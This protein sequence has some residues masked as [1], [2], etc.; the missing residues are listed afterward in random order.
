MDLLTAQI[1]LA[2]VDIPAF[3][4]EGSRKEELQWSLKQLDG[5][6]DTVWPILY[7]QYLRRRKRCKVHNAGPAN[8]WLRE[9]VGW[10]QKILAKLPVSLSALRNE[11][12]RAEVAAD[13]ANQ[14]AQL[15]HHATD[16]H[17]KTVDPLDLFDLVSG[18]AGQWGF[19]PAMPKF[20]S[21]ENRDA[22]IA[23]VL[24]RLLDAKWWT[25]KINRAWDRYTEHAA[26]LIGKVRRGVSAYLSNTNLKIYRQRKEAAK[27]WAADLLVVN[28]QHGL[29][30]SLA[31]AIKASIA[32]PENRRHELMVRMR[33]F[34]DT[35][36]DLGHLGL[37]ITWT[38][39][40]KFHPW[41]TRGGKQDGKTVEN[42]RYQGASPRETQRY[43]CKLW[44]YARAELKRQ[45]I[46]PY[47]F[48]VVE[49]HHDGTPH[50]HMLLFIPPEQC[51][52]LIGTLQ[53][54]ALLHDQA[55]LVR[56]RNQWGRYC[57]AFTDITPRF[58][59]KIMNPAEGGAT[60][61]LAK[62][63]AKNIDGHRVGEDYEAGELSDHAAI[64]ACGWASWHGLRQFQQIGG[65]GV[66]IWRELRRLPDLPGPAQDPQLELCRA[67]ASHPDWAGYVREMG[68]P[69]L[70][71]ADRPVRLLKQIDKA[72]SRY[73]ED[74]TRLL[75]VMGHRVEI[76]TRLDGWEI[77]R[78]GLDERLALAPAA[79]QGGAL[80]HGA[81]GAP[82]S[83]DNNCTEGSP[84]G[85]AGDLDQALA[86]QAPLL[87]LSER[88]LA[89]LHQ[90]CIVSQ[91]GRYMWIT[92][93]Q[94]HVS[95]SHPTAR[96]PEV[97]PDPGEQDQQAELRAKQA[98][99]ITRQ[100]RQIWH[101][102]DTGQDVAP[103]LDS[104]PPAEQPMAVAQLADILDQL[105]QEQYIQQL[106]EQRGT[107]HVLR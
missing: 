100:R 23:A 107:R 39:P 90:G 69:I 72:A 16:G 77:S 17:T 27:R 41:K 83:S 53:R 93:S 28:E 91:D 33:G 50:W 4:P 57:P 5:L 31:D 62:Y 95:E 15:L 13:W 71:R 26:I 9:R 86:D 88:D 59:W 43:L 73:G 22:W 104:L 99:H 45:E 6:P 29:E 10:F 35:A 79:R 2:G 52:A 30:I 81:A 66:G 60:G 7:V 8:I 37:F 78:H 92:G 12:R 76:E 68:G 48:R 105:D 42:E 98:A 58:D 34:E 24:V 61:Y 94:L 64:A 82:W 106:A 47:G 87:G 25:R 63:I 97:A 101:L 67:M 84:A 21:V 80:G 3:F 49:P 55:E 54:Y 46:S 36:A 103:W 102:L 14:T 40:S 65:P 96:P 20:K 70:P 56:T 32:N 11:E 85:S 44:S 19:V 51:H 18:P 74:V 89:L 38:A 75:G 1:K